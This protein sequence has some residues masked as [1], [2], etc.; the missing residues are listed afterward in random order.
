M[1]K[2][3]SD[4]TDTTIVE[5]PVSS[6]GRTVRLRASIKRKFKEVKEASLGRS[7]SVSLGST[8]DDD[9]EL[10]QRT[11]GRH[12]RSLS[13]ATT[14]P[15]PAPTPPPRLLHA[16]TAPPAIATGTAST[17][18]AATPV[19]PVSAM[20]SM[21]VV[22]DEDGEVIVPQLLQQG[23]LM[24]KVSNKKHKRAVFRLDPDIGHI[25]WEGK[26][27]RLSTSSPLSVCFLP[28]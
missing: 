14:T 23:T 6:L 16:N 13:T 8:V 15:T 21:P 28:I 24:T 9:G 11:V 18:A 1:C 22:M 17:A 4:S 20:P 2:E 25:I 3:L 10:K 5:S 7:K 27:H 19:L 26:Q 12:A